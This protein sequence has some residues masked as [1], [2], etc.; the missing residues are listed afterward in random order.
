MVYAMLT[1]LERSKPASPGTGALHFLLLVSGKSDGRLIILKMYT[2]YL[3]KFKL[4]IF[5]SS[6]QKGIIIYMII[7]ETLE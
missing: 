6:S 3:E 1:L 4:G 7:W 5:F 2:A